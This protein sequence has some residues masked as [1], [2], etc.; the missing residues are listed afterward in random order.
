MEAKLDMI[1]ISQVADGSFVLVEQN[2][3][4]QSKVSIYTD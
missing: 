1:Q 3:I 2:A 4:Y